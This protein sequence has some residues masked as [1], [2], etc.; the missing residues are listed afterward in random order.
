MGQG[1]I[2]VVVPVKHLNAAITRQLLIYT[3]LPLAY[4][5]TGRLGLLLAVPPGYATAVFMPAG[6][7][8]GAMFMAGASSLPGILIGSLLLNVWIGYAI[9]DQFVP[10]SV[11]TAFVIAVASTVQAALG[12]TVLR[13]VIGY[14]AAL[15]N[16]RDLVRLLVLAPLFCVTSATLS[17]AAMWE[18][19]AVRTGDL[20]SNWMT[21]WVGD[22]L[23]VLVALPLLFVLAAEPRN[24]WRSRIWTVA[25]PMLLCF[26][27]FVAIFIRV[28][29]WENDQSLFE[30]RLRSEQFAGTLRGT[31]EEQRGF[32]EQLSDAFVSRH[33][34]VTSQEFRDL[35]QT[36]LQR[37]PI[38][39]AVEWAPLVQSAERARF[40]AAQRAEVPGFE[41]RQRES[42]GEMR[43]ADDRIRFYPITYVEPPRGNEQAIGFDL[44]S[45]ETRRVAIEAATGSGNL[46]ATAPIRLVQEQGSQNGILLIDA[47]SSG[48][49]GPGV[50]LV[51]LRMGAFATSL[52][53]PL[54]SILA[55]R[56]TDAAVAAPF[57]DAIPR[58]VSVLFKTEFN[59]GGRR[60]LVSTTPSPPYLATRQ[61]W[62]SW[63]VLAAG[64]LGTGLIGGLL[65][66]GTGHGHRFGLLAKKL[67]ENE[68]SLREK[69]AELES[70]IYR[71]PFMLI[72]LDRDL[73]YRFISQAYLEMTGRRPERVIGK[74]LPEVLGDKDFQT[75]RPHIEKVLQ[76]KRVEFEREVHYEGVGTRFLH[77][78]YTPEQNGSGTVTGWIASMLDIT[79]RKRAEEEQRRAA[80]A[81]QILIRELQ[82]RTNNLLA[83][84]QG[85]AQKTLSGSGPLDEARKIFEGRLLALAGTYR[86]L[87]RSNWSGVSLREIVDLT[88]DPFGARIEIDGPDLMLSA[89]NAQNFSLALHELATNALKHGALSS[90]GGN[91]RIAWTIVGN[92]GG[93]ILKFRWQERGGPPVLG[94]GQRGFGT[95]L[96]ESTFKTVNLDYA[97]EGL[98][99]DIDV[100]LGTIE[101]VASPQ[102]ST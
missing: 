54:R 82:H 75:I 9:A 39:Q 13:R 42:S 63:A 25:V 101:F 23:G 47:V 50:V 16:P 27:L 26:A 74:R 53:E 34:P 43:A 67:R 7:A 86:Q 66:L 28:N 49:S 77:V 99:C 14:P 102:L 85:I 96:L 95:L 48:P 68:A 38:I 72:R 55:L 83:V 98:T 40:E 87:T 46:A 91:V 57:Y 81:E 45:D 52:V 88:L 3:V 4:V 37:F 58:T 94:P 1:R 30:F 36:L 32:L 33:Q 10:S 90:A 8:V 93:S 11:E 6:I 73:R 64:A 100:P 71:T 15:D 80:D 79:E 59:F 78:I 84:I 44:A 2:D 62:Q 92:G 17:L 20:P 76:G 97:R 35:V 24:L 18:L 41:I 89:K 65:L 19:G 21:W 29:S 69:E 5:T 61:G 22:T 12:G 56:F 31:L 51:A 70:I 60:Y